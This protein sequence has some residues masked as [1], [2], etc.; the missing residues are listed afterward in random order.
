MSN[1]ARIRRKH[2]LSFVMLSFIALGSSLNQG[3]ADPPPGYYDTVDATNATTLRSTLHPVIDDHTR[4][5]YTSTAT[6][7]WN[8]LESA[9][10]DPNNASNILDVYMNASIPKFGGGVGPY[11]REH[12]W[13]SSYGFPND[14]SSNMPYTD[15]HMLH[16]SDGG[17]NGSR[18][19]KPYRNCS[20]ACSEQPTNVNNGQGGG[21]GVYP[22]NSNWTTGS[23][24]QGTWETWIGKRGNVAR[25]ILYMDIRYEGGTHGVTGVAE[26]DLIVT[27]SEALIDA[28]N[29]GANIS[30]AYMGMLAALLQWHVQDPVDADERL[31]NDVVFGYQGNRNPFVDHPEWVACLYQGTCGC[32]VPADCDDGFFCN[33]AESCVASACQ[34]GTDPCPGQGCDEVNNVCVPPPVSG[35]PFINEFH[36]DN[37]GTDTGE[38]VEIAGPEGTN[39]SGWSVVGYNGTGG[40]SYQTVNLSGIIPDQGG[41]MGTL[42]FSF[43]G[44]QNGAP[45]GLALVN[46]SGAVLQFLSYEGAFVATS[47]PANGMTSVNIVVSEEPAPPIG[48]SLQVAGT[49]AVAADFTWQAP[50]TSTS[51]L[52][53]NGQTFDGCGGCTSNPQCD[54]G[55]FCNGAETC[56]TGACQPGSPVNCADSVSCTVDSCNETTDTCDHIPDNGVCGDG[57][58]CTGVETCHV[59]LGC[60]AGT[61]VNCND[62]VA[63]TADSCNETTDSCNN[64]PNNASCDDGLFC[65]GAETC[66]ATL[67]CQAGA[68][69]CAPNPCDEPTDSCILPPSAELWIV[70]TDDAT[71]PGVG[72]ATN[73]DIV[74]YDTGTGLWSLVFD[75]SD[76]GLASFAIDG[77]AVLP[78]GK[79]LLSFTVAGTVGGVAM[80]DSDILEFTPISL[81]STTS[82]TFAMYFDG[83]D[84]GLSTNDED[85]DALGLDAGGNLVISVIGAFTANGASGVDEDLFVFTATSLG[86]NTAGIF[87]MLFDGSDVGL[88]TTNDEDVDSAGF[89]SGGTILL[90]TLGNFSVTG[91]SG[92]D[93]D[94]FEFTPTQLGATTSGTY[95]MFL[96]LST[97]GIDPAEDVIAVHLIE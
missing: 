31:R 62:G 49:G 91:V 56:V 37:A 73:E 5:P 12:T 3:W 61:A 4:F 85:V 26:P 70:F 11:E 9:D 83:S 14:N 1:G 29:T 38:F 69:P 27:D 2:G 28:S 75:G 42:S 65:N 22:G 79:L 48:Q 71:V 78:S 93:E 41:C 24:T 18:S 8:I 17:Y 74:A 77:M 23:L 7:T 67:G 15:C 58:F 92:A 64:V 54:D 16:L 53:N 34:S 57:L 82:G 47:G 51:G 45:D 35:D 39:L 96:D 76:V 90:S 50:A 88:S 44:T 10:Q 95:S 80:D 59:T 86:T 68:D 84:V 32:S 89:T 55:V 52:P 19:N 43:A 87:A 63:C 72:T 13:P 20:A 66:H 60:Q 81:G 21:T 46:G 25:A 30:V 40:A 6:D 97:T 36:Y 33:G 94:V